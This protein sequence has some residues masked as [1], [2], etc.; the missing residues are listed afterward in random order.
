MVDEP[1]TF[2]S[3]VTKQ[4]VAVADRHA[5]GKVLLWE[6]SVGR[7]QQQGSY[8]L[9]DFVIREYACSRF[10]GFSQEGSQILPIADMGVVKQLDGEEDKLEELSAI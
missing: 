3:G 2:S 1:V 6:G 8:T 5:V 4:D 10:L 9:K 7:L